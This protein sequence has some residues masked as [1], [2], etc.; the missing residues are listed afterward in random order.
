MQSW[1]KYFHSFTFFPRSHFVNYPMPYLTA[2]SRWL[3]QFSEPWTHS[4]WDM[5]SYEMLRFFSF[6]EWEQW[7]FYLWFAM[8]TETGWTS[9]AHPPIPA[10]CFFAESTHNIG[11]EQEGNII[12]HSVL[13][14][15]CDLPH[16]LAQNPPKGMAQQLLQSWSPRKWYPCSRGCYCLTRR[17]VI[18]LLVAG[19]LCWNYHP[20]NR[21]VQLWSLESFARK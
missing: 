8:A 13:K 17:C 2:L 5:L 20:R 11:E 9:K 21:I 18:M 1:E 12:F 3:E 19:H 16:S 7:C 6:W 4:W 14:T 15:L 10:Y